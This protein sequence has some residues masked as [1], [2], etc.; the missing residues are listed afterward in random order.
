MNRSRALRSALVSAVL[1]LLAGAAWLT[2]AP[3]RV[4]GSTDYVTTHGTSM[5]PRFH[6]GDLA[7]IRPADDYRVG[8]VVAYRSALLRTVVLHRIIG[9]EGD[10]YVFKGDNNG[11]VDP[12][13]PD[14]SQLVGKLWLR[15]PRAGVLLASVRRP[16]VSGALVGGASL[17]LRLGAGTQRRRRRRAAPA[18]TP[19]APAPVRRPAPVPPVIGG[20]HLA[21]PKAPKPPTEAPPSP[22]A[23]PPTPAAG[24]APVAVSGD[25]QP[26]DRRSEGVSGGGA[27]ARPSA[28]TPRI[29]GHRVL[30]ASAIAAALFVLSA[31]AAFTTGTTRQTTIKTP[32]EES[33][34]FGYHATPRPKA[35]PVYPGGALSTGDP[36]FLKLVDQVSVTVGYRFSAD[37]PHQLAGRLGV[38]LRV[39]SPT[40]WTRDLPLTPPTPFHGDRADTDVTIDLARVRRITRQVER[41]TGMSPG[42]SYSLSVI[43]RL[44]AQGKLAGQPLKSDFAPQMTFQLDGLQLRPG[45]RTLAPTKNSSVAVPHTVANTFSVRGVELPVRTARWLALGGLLLALLGALISRL[46]RFRRPADPSGRVHAR[47]GHLLVPIAGVAPHPGRTPID[48]TTIDALVALAERGE[49]LILHHHGEDADTYLVEDGG[50][51]FRFR[52]E[53]DAPRPPLVLV[54]A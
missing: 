8:D 42:G 46:P 33:V 23:A 13:H 20:M 45:D 25:T 41:L 1:V 6:T 18:P 7:L 17:L 16:L 34:T 43:P 37:A 21:P 36:V 22:A 53:H 48:V 31:L 47:Y 39:A 15:V 52:I 14:R 24:R 30:Q 3:T 50:T 4:G 54:A 5:A 19:V 44:S 40:G 10:R 29:D 12:T 2:L 9:R 49:R 26:G 32:Y 11:F 51:L 28:T 35:G 27:G 38:I